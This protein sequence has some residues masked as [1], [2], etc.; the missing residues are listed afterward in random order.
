MSARAMEERAQ[1]VELCTLR[2]FRGVQAE[3][4][5]RLVES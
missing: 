4:P 2:C 5:E 3:W 1:T